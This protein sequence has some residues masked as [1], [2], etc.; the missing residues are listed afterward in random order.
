[1]HLFQVFPI[2]FHSLVTNKVRSFLTALGVVFGVG[3]VIAMLSISEG[4]RTEATEQVRLLGA[5][6]VFIE[7][8]WADWDQGR[9][10]GLLLEDGR[11][12]GSLEVLSSWT[13]LR[14]YHDLIV[15]ARGR[16]VRAEIVCTTPGFREILD[17]TLDRGRYFD[18]VD[19][20]G[21][22]M[23]CVL[24][25]SLKK[26]IFAF[27]D[28]CGEQVKIDDSWF[29]VVGVAE[30]RKFGRSRV[31]GLRLPHYNTQVFV[32]HTVAQYFERERQRGTR[33]GG[34]VDEII[35]EVGGPRD[36]VPVSILA[37]RLLDRL[38]AGAEDFKIVVPQALL[39][40]SR[41]T[42]RTFSIVMGAIAGISLLV[43]GIGIMNIML[44]TV[45]ERR[46][47]IG[48][49]RAAGATSRAV[50]L[51]FVVEAVVLSLVGC[52][53]GIGVGIVMSAL[54]AK[55]AAWITAINALH[56]I[57]AVGVAAAVGILSGFY[58]ARRAARIDP[59]EALR[60]E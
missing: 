21:A 5:N 36:V 7:N 43:G 20:E 35:I 28:A 8:A 50:L 14:R 38:H 32:P 29:T 23:V 46:H 59:G 22:R 37:G 9:T 33:P 18:S 34:S 57:I 48:V 26:A 41:R 30:Y 3:A 58:P 53:V 49:R 24:G 27:E 13:V 25:S 55:Y 51:Q 54:V 17:L 2:A 60:Y 45:L 47:E 52:A 16:R 1:M 56:I 11:A 19:H 4:A 40:Q 15:Q 12:L 6:T 42:Q 39:A 10:D 44:A 31:K